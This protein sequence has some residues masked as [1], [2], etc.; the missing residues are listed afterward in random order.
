[1]SLRNDCKAMQAKNYNKQTTTT[2]KNP[3]P[4]KCQEQEA[5]HKLGRACVKG[6]KE[7]PRESKA[8]GENMTFVF[9]HL[10]SQRRALEKLMPALSIMGN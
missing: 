3:F 2:T 4:I 9:S 10:Y 5:C 6:V 1:M 7:T 8:I